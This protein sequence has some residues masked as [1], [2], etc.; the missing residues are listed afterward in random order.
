MQHFCREYTMP[1]NEKKTRAKGWILKNTRIGPVLNIKVCRLED[2]YSIDVL[3]ES[4]FQDRAASWLRIVSGIDKYVAESMQTKEE[5]HGALGRPV[6]NARPR[7]KPAVKLSS[8]SIP[9]RGRKW[10]DI[11]TP[12]SHVQACYQVSK[13][14]IRLLRHDRTLGK[15][16]EQFHLTSWMHAGRRSSMVLRS[17][18]LKIGN[19]LWQKEEEPRKGFDIV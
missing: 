12:R 17:G 13:A 8:V 9:V 11:E 3:I 18:H 4:L 16:T 1:R 2:R 14:M 6:A 10:I 19:Q 15:L 7:L 5:E